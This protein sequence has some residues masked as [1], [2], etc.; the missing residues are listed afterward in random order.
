MPN[1]IRKTCLEALAAQRGNKLIKVVTGA[2]RVG[3]STLMAQYMERLSIEDPNAPALF[4]NFDVPIYRFLAEKGWNAALDAIVQAISPVRTNYLFLDEIQNVPHYEKLLLGLFVHPQIDLYITG[5]NTCLQS[6]KLAALLAGRSIEVHVLPLSFSEYIELT[7]AAETENPAAALGD[8]LMSGGIPEAVQLA[9]IDPAC[10]AQYLQT[11]YNR[12]Y[13]SDIRPRHK[14]RTA[15]SYRDVANF[16]AENIG[17]PVSPGGIAKVLT[18]GGAKIDNK[19]ASKYCASLVD[20]RLFY[21]ADRWDIE[22]N[23]LLATREKYYAV[24]TGL[25]NAL[26]AKNPQNDRARLLENAVFL[27]LI[28]RKYQIWAGKAGAGEIN[29]VAR[30]SDGGTKYI[31]VEQT[32]ESPEALARALAPF[33]KIPARAE[34]ILIT[35]DQDSGIW[36]GVRQVNAAVWLMGG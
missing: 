22:K 16:L 3:K 4:I 27:E 21:R 18:D 5:S 8:Y 2:R 30:D 26:L 34:K 32:V 23:R 17:R 28:R 12:V 6:G 20:S 24:D 33:E 11:V 15:A 19:S 13:E 14:I 10:P 7:G 35:E 9:A 1:V 29:F 25:R 31:H 36:N